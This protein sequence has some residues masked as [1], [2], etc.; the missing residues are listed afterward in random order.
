MSKITSFI[1][2]GFVRLD[3]RKHE[4]LVTQL[5][6]SIRDAI[7]T[8]QLRKMH[9]LPSTRALATEL[10]VSRTT[11]INAFEQLTAEGYLAGTVG[12]GTY[13]S[14]EL[15]EDRQLAR[16]CEIGRDN[17]SP[18]N[19]PRSNASL[20]ERGRKFTGGETTIPAFTGMVKPFRPGIPAL[21]EFPIET[22]SRLCRR[23]WKH[24]SI[25]DLS[26]G[27]PAGYLPLRSAIADY[28]RGFRG[29]RCDDD[30]VF[31]VSGTQQAVDIV[32]R[33]IID[34]GDK[35]LFENPGYTRARSTFAAANAKI[36]PIEVDSNGFNTVE[37]L[38]TAP[39]ARLAYVTPSHQFPLGVTL[40]IER[41]MQ[42]I[43]WANETGGMIFEDD[44]DSEFRY[45]HRPIPAMQGLDHGE[46][47]IYVGSFSKV[48]YP[49]LSI[50][51]AIVP[52]CMIDGFSNAVAL[53]GRPAST[54][55]Q[56]VL[57]DFINEDHFARHLRRMRKIHEQ[58]RH[59]LVKGIELYLS[60]HLEVIGSDA[61]LHCS[62]RLLKRKDDRL[63]SRRIA[64]CGVVA[65]ALSEYALGEK[66]RSTCPPGL[67]F[68][69]AC[70]KPPEI[71]AS[72]KKIQNLI[73]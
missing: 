46:R 73:G 72:L 35:V 33:L 63:L 36:V 62:A 69:F 56:M 61:G 21:D 27:D 55:D 1:D 44:Y 10:G 5:Y 52:K 4:S 22:W 2:L 51:Y 39:D 48:I 9:R 15:P 53:S 28:V 8:G 67:I 6:Q 24:V 47:T 32:A 40:S 70:C 3:R 59:T 41:R 12:R 58:R 18:S 54:V 30:Q 14:D 26:Y 38:Q 65:P 49:S 19:L 7:L 43:Q 64:E 17:E 71:R 66:S 45:A 50:G 11:V 29:V 37:A 13:V 34:P 23:R 42:L 68:G 60:N 25:A 57:T 31:I 16:F 20:S